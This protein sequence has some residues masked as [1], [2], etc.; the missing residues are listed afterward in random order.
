M[1]SV[2]KNAALALLVFAA[3]YLITSL[4]DYWRYLVRRIR[5][6]GSAG[7]PMSQAVLQ[8]HRVEKM[9]SRFRERYQAVFIYSYNVGGQW[10]SGSFCSRKF[11]SQ[12]DAERLLAKYPVNTS[13]MV[14][15]SPRRSKESLLVLPE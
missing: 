15:V 12:A 2:L 10:Y 3:L 1:F 4:P 5:Y 14:R 7:W 11:E 8:E 9:R 13:V 6:C